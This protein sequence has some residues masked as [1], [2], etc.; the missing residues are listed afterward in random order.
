LGHKELAKEQ[1]DIALL[2]EANHTGA[3]IHRGLI[4]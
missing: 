2:K 1:F 4:E 3:R